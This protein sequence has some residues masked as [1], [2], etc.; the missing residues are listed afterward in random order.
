LSWTMRQSKNYCSE[1]D[2]EWTEWMEAR[3]WW[4]VDVVVSAY[5]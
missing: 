4:T 3:L 2:I 5:C 1:Y